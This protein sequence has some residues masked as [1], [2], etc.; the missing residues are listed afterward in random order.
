MTDLNYTALLLVIDRSGSMTSIRDDMVGGLTSMLADQAAQPGM[1]TVDVVDF[2]QEI[3]LVT[4]MADAKSMTIELDPRGS[5]ALYDA[6]GFAVRGFGKTLEALPEHARPDTVQV[7]VV[8]DGEENA[9]QEY[10]ADTVRT[11]IKRQTEKY[12]WDFVF[13][14]ANQDAV[15]TGARLGFD[16]DSSMTF[17]AAP[18]QVGATSESLSRYVKDVRG[19]TKRGFND[20]ERRAAGIPS[21]TSR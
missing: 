1:L 12:S 2:D 18:D 13:L 17:A 16:A 19:K 6:I 11:L 10:T 9:S 8:T 5:T 14:G 3:R 21:D 7:V 15:L 20:T 4:S